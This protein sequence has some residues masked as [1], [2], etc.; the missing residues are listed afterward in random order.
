MTYSGRESKN[1]NMLP[2]DNKL[3]FVIAPGSDHT[4]CL[5]LEKLVDYI[6]ENSYFSVQLSY[7]HDYA[8]AIDQLTQGKAQIG[9]LGPYAYIE[10]SRYGAVEQFAI[11][12]P[13]GKQ[14]SNYQSVFI[15]R[16]SSDIKNIDQ[17]KN[18]RIVVGDHHSTSGYAVPKKELAEVGIHLENS[19][20]FQEI[21][22]ANTHEDAIR[23]VIEGIADIAPVSSVNL[24]ENINSGKLDP[25]QIRIIHKSK[26]IPGAPLV[27]S[28]FLPNEIKDQLRKLVL[29]AHEVIDVG[30]YGGDMDRYIDPEQGKRDL[31]DSYIKRPQWGWKSYLFVFCL[32]SMI[33]LVGYDLDINP[34]DVLV[35]STSYLADIFGRMLPPDFSGFQNLMSAMVET[36]EIAFL[37]TVIAIALS[38][39]IGLLS[40]RNVS[41]NFIVFIACRSII[42][43]FRAVPE[44]IM[45]MILVI[46]IG[47]GAMPGVL[48]LGLHTMGF[49]AKFY[50]EDIE[51]VDTGPIEAMESIGASNSQRIAFAIVPQVL[52]SFIGYNLY[53]FDRNIRMAT[54]LGIVGAGG[55][56]YELQSAFRMFNYPRVSAIII[57]IF[58]VIFII[59]M[60]SS[61]IRKRL[62]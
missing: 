45:A 62:G 27:Y 57:V 20:D 36:I 17:V 52:T 47:F 8:E 39:P 9:W 54:M 24:E 11:G 6:N 56:G 60:I 4:G 3:I 61:A 26:D 28:R 46:A 14:N 7:C 35:N 22:N 51:H 44:F 59:D 32:L 55:I 40:A 30:G 12:L 19:N 43:F 34:I 16:S 15:V 23:C 1:S 42:V 25:N 33:G 31:L 58:I 53:I 29:K 41:P 2:E 5:N 50:A 21:I 38:I 18:K 10:A 48:A 49:L 37:G 13:K